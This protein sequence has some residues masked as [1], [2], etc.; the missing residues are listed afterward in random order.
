MKRTFKNL[1]KDQR[2]EFQY[3]GL[4]ALTFGAIIFGG[5]FL[6]KFLFGKTKNNFQVQRS[7]RGMRR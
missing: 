3:V 6:L 4:G 7:S 5:Y 1:L 2:G